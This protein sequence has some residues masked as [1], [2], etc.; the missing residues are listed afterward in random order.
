MYRI[1]VVEDDAVIAGA[2]CREL[3]AWGY[4]A[5]TAVDF[6]DVM[7]E[8]RAFAPHLVLMDVSLPFHNGY[9]HCAEIRRESKAP[10]DF[11]FLP[12][13][14]YGCCD[15][16]EYGRGRLYHKAISLEVLVQGA[17]YAPPQLRL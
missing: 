12:C 3:C 10:G 8:F 2:I 6:A 11:C 5:R 9:F 7:G 1:F 13:G 4:E 15:G 14:E 16:R 17:G